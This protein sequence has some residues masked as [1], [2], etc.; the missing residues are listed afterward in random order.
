MEDEVV[1]VADTA[2]K[3]D[4]LAL[5]A[6]IDIQENDLAKQRQAFEE[7]MR[8]VERYLKDGALSR[9]DDTW[10][11]VD[12]LEEQLRNFMEEQEQVLGE[13]RSARAGWENR[14]EERF[15]ECGVQLERVLSTVADLR[16]HWDTMAPVVAARQWRRRLRRYRRS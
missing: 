6:K 10:V 12:R 7:R 2:T 8:G 4:L 15:N 11:R 9:A 14:T 5:R 13:A 3:G 16:T 1:V